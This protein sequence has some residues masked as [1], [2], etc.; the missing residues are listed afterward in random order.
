MDE[1]KDLKGKA[2]IE[3]RINRVRRGLMGDCR[4]VGDGIT[5]LKID[6]G[7]GYRVY[8]FIDGRAVLLLC[9]GS[10]RTQDADIARAKNHLREYRS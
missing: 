10:K 8:C 3:K 1:L 5:E 9:G 2:Q 4:E 7:P 6:F